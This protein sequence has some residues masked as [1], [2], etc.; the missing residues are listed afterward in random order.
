MER[1]LLNTSMEPE[2]APPEPLCFILGRDQG[3]RWIVQETH[4]LC[5]GLFASKDAAIRF[6]KFES[7]DRE[8]VIRLAPDPIELNCSC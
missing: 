4:G 2:E 1:L 8:S 5:G 6:A 7:A 3:G